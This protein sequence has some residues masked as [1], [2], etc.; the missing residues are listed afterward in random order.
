LLRF[1]VN[2]IELIAETEDDEYWNCE[3][4]IEKGWINSRNCKNEHY[5]S[6]KGKE[7]KVNKYS[8]DRKNKKNE[9]VRT[10]SFLLPDD[11]KIDYCPMGDFDESVFNLVN[12]ILWSEEIKIL[13]FLPNALMEQPNKYIEARWA[14]IGQR[15]KIR[16]I[17]DKKEKQKQKQK[18][19]QRQK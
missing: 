12:L 9:E 18:N 10:R 2:L 6:L 7:V 1:H 8:L 4:C 19:N 3:K 13:P 16:S 15:S 14:V 17:R 5:D 11:T